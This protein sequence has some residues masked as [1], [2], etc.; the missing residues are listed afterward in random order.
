MIPRLTGSKWETQKPTLTQPSGVSVQEINDK[1]ATLTQRNGVS[2]QYMI[3]EVIL[4][5]LYGGAM[6]EMIYKGKSQ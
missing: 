1:E 2:V 3:Q 6:Q 5:K 4:I